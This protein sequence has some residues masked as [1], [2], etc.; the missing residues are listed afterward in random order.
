LVSGEIILGAQEAQLVA[1]DRQKGEAEWSCFD[2]GRHLLKNG[3]LR[4]TWR[5]R[6]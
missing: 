1:I 4:L 3:A 2:S 6:P 5:W